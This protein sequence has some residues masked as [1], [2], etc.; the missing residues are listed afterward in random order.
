MA[1]Q[2]LEQIIQ[3]SNAPGSPGE[4]TSDDVLKRNVIKEVIYKQS[5][6]LAV[7]TNILPERN[8]NN[9]DV[10]FAF[11]S[12]INAEYP[13]GENSVVDR[14][15]VTWQE[16]DMSLHQAEAR[17]MITDMAQLRQQGDVQNETST[18][19]AAEA[20]AE[21]KD[22]NILSTLQA[23]SPT[24][25]TVTNDTSSD[26][27]WNQSNGDPE[28]DIMQAWNH[29]FEQSNVRETDLD[30]SHLV[31]PASVY[32]ELTSLQLINNVQ[33]NIRDYI[34]GSLGLNIWFSRYFDTDAILCV[35]GEETGIHGVLDTNDIPL[36]EE[37]RQLGRGTDYLSRQF[38]NTGI[39][40]DSDL[41]E[42]SYRISTI[43]NVST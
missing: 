23:G 13:V 38:F 21:E 18:R 33:Q 40:E 24:I 4:T 43:E 19:R 37:E 14:S 34:E 5:D 6:L 20:L 29:I 1:N 28:S 11:P 3:D 39:M 17:F 16:M 25:N 30:R 26:E 7:G 27:A 36:V 2:T 31:V 32:S 8:F 9:L 42:E 10:T 15:K 41:S 12:E 22:H 35:G